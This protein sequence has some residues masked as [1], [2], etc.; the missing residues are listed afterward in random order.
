M[1]SAGK[2]SILKSAQIQLAQIELNK[3]EAVKKLDIKFASADQAKTSFGY[4]GIICISVLFGVFFLNDFLKLCTFL[5]EKFLRK[6]RRERRSA[7]ISDV[8][9][10]LDQEKR[11]DQLNNQTSEH[12]SSLIEKRLERVHFFLI[13]AKLTYNSEQI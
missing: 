3:Q 2:A 7:K 10:K 9:S 5:I 12:F 6:K 11:H 1:M 8:S 4:I 13:Q